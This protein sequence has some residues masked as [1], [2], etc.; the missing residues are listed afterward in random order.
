MQIRSSAIL[1]P[2]C[3]ETGRRKAESH[4]VPTAR[5]NVVST[6]FRGGDYTQGGEI[7][8]HIAYSEKVVFDMTPPV[9][10]SD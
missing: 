2:V 9:P 1:V 10:S 4:R 6:E 8:W 7:M 3:G 5:V